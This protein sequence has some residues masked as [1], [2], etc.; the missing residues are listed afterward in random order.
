M[1]VHIDGLDFSVL[2]PVKREAGHLMLGFD[3][4]EAFLKE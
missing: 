3:N 4:V 2:G 1:S